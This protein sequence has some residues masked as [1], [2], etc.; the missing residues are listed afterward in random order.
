MNLD[1][2]AYVDCVETLLG[3]HLWLC[4][5]EI[6]HEGNDLGRD[7]VAALGT[8]PARQQTGEPTSLQCVLGFVEGRSGDAERRRCFADGKAVDLMAPHHL[9]AHLDQVLCI[10]ERIAGEQNIANGRGIGIEDTVLRQR[11]ALRVPSFWLRH[12]QPR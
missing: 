2:E 12:A 3:R 8:A 7:L 11:L 9:V 6:G 5:S 1:P 4:R 10:E